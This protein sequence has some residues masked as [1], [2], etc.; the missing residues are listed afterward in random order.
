MIDSAQPGGRKRTDS[1]P[2]GVYIEKL[3]RR[4]I[5]IAPGGPNA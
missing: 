4:A 5:L 1:F 2:Y 3:S